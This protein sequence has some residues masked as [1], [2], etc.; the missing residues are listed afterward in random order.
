MGVMNYAATLYGPVFTILGVV[1]QL[2]VSSAGPVD[3]L[4]LDKTAGVPVADAG[5]AT[6]QRIVPAVAIRATDLVALGIA[7]ADLDG[8]AIFMNG[9]SWEILNHA[10]VPA[11]TGEEQGEV[12]AYLESV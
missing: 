2:D 12:W 7:P 4:V 3:I 9:R 10:L 5:D 6:V 11:P 8:G 1:A